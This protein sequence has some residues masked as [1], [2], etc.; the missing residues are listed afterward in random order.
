M[1]T[2]PLKKPLYTPVG[3]APPREI[4]AQ[5]IIAL[6]DLLEERNVKLDDMMCSWLLV[7]SIFTLNLDILE[8]HFASWLQSVMSIPFN[9][10]ADMLDCI[11][12]ALL[13]RD[14]SDQIRTILEKA[15]YQLSSQAMSAIISWYSD[16]DDINSALALLDKVTQKS[17]AYQGTPV[18]FGFLLRYCQRKKDTA[19]AYS[20]WQ[21][22]KTTKITLTES[23]FNDVRSQTQITSRI[24]PRFV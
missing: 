18:T 22:L 9:Q 4:D 7:A 17:A 20:I 19:L 12:Y 2:D 11:V 21:R 24:F 1:Q 5:H 13:D 8:K 10:R 23:L 3:S 16:Q 6:I 15:S 14:L